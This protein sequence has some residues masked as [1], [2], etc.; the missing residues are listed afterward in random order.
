[1]RRGQGRKGRIVDSVEQR[2]GQ[3]GQWIFT[4][5]VFTKFNNLFS[6]TG[7]V[8]NTCYILCVSACSTSLCTLRLEVLPYSPACLQLSAQSPALSTTPSTEP[9]TTRLDELHRINHI[10]TQILDKKESD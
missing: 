1:M 9:V 5:L 8:Y 4:G 6:H 2:E 10:N 7:V 3:Q